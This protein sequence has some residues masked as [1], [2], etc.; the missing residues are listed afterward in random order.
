MLRRIGGCLALLAVLAAFGCGKSPPPIV[1][2]EGTVLLNG[3][4][5]PNAQVEFVPELKDFG[6]E[7]NSTAT[8]DD[9][10]HFKLTCNLNQQTGACVGSHRVLIS[11][12]P[13]PGDLRGQDAATQAKLAQ[14]QARL[15]N[16]PIPPQYSSVS[17]TPLRFE[18]KPDQ[19][20]YQIDLQR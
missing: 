7:M 8:T 6:A 2:V 9:K 17:K 15:K 10:G 4:P 20:T 3:Q 14:F 16:R 5:L 1:E 11:E 18:V 12:P 13:T 19:K